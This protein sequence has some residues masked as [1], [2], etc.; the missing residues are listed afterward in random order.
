MARVSSQPVIDTKSTQMADSK[1]AVCSDAPALKNIMSVQSPT[2]PRLQFRHNSVP[3]AA[4]TPAGAAHQ[5]VKRPLRAAATPGSILRRTR[6]TALTEN[7]TLATAQPRHTRPKPCSRAASAPVTKAP[8]TANTS[9]AGG[10]SFADCPPVMKG[11]VS[12]MSQE[13]DLHLPLWQQQERQHQQIMLARLSD[14][15]SH[16]AQWPQASSSDAQ[17]G[18]VPPTMG[19]EQGTAVTSAQQLL[20]AQRGEVLPSAQQAS[21]C[22]HHGSSDHLHLRQQQLHQ[23]QPLQSKANGSNMQML[24]HQ[25]A[26][27][28]Q[29]PDKGMQQNLPP[30]QHQRHAQQQPVSLSQHGLNQSGGAQ[31]QHHV[32][33]HWQ[34]QQPSQHSHQDEQHHPQPHQQQ[35]QQPYQQMQQPAHQEPPQHQQR[36]QAQ[37]GWHGHLLTNDYAADLTVQKLF[38]T[39]HKPPRQQ[40]GNPFADPTPNAANERAQQHA[41]A[42]HHQQAQTHQTAAAVAGNPA[43]V[44]GNPAAVAGSPAAVAGKHATAASSSA[45]EEGAHSKPGRG[46]D[47]V[48][49]VHARLEQARCDSLECASVQ[50]LESQAMAA[51]QDACLQE[52][53]VCA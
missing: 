35:Q 27:A 51:D 39:P 3:H 11:A 25:F 8:G 38:V 18:A 42:A 37:A 34:H 52:L 12:R 29:H 14:S 16:S 44:A 53:Q 36:Q 28:A 4:V 49:H 45:A 46:G 23:Q 15:R 40:S 30:E 32:Q 43:A 19:S 2:R 50:D 48:A 9:S 6:S 33:Q 13:A 10:T 21:S 41:M 5:S 20:Q 47:G 22:S 1:L 31:Q 7:E 26:A 24:H 17:H